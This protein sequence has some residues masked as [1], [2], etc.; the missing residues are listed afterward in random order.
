MLLR[1]VDLLKKHQYFFLHKTAI[2]SSFRE[3]GFRLHDPKEFLLVIEYWSY[4]YFG[5]AVTFIKVFFV[6]QH[7]SSDPL[8]SGNSEFNLLLLSHVSLRSK[9]PIKS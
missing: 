6:M 5:L 4:T 8:I 2:F 9:V 3:G 1:M 7:I